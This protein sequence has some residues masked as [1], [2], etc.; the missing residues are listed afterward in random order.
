MIRLT[1]LNESRTVGRIDYFKRC[2]GKGNQTL[3]TSSDGSWLV[4][5]QSRKVRDGYLIEV[6]LSCRGLMGG[7]DPYL[8]W[9]M[10]SHD[11]T[12]DIRYGGSWEVTETSL[13][14]EKTASRVFN[15]ILNAAL[16]KADLDLM[17]SDRERIAVTKRADSYARKNGFR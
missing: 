15:G 5:S 17:G 6:D 14:D 12:W 4:L 7:S 3:A 11:G 2:L 13:D 10:W 1:N 8:Q 16:S 9:A